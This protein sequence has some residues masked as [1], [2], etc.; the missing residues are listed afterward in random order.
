MQSPRKQDQEIF[1]NQPTLPE[2]RAHDGLA[3][4]LGYTQL[5]K[6]VRTDNHGHAVQLNVSGWIMPY[7]GPLPR[8]KYQCTRNMEGTS[9]Q[10][11]AIRNTVGGSMMIDSYLAH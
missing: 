10:H 4:R 3:R 2:R 7:A 9:H 1:G 6:S 5:R 11:V 8:S